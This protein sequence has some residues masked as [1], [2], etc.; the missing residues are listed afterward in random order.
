MPNPDHPLSRSCVS[1]LH[2]FPVNMHSAFIR[3]HGVKA[4][5]AGCSVIEN[6]TVLQRIYRRIDRIP[7]LMAQGRTQI[8]H[9][10]GIACFHI[11]TSASAFRYSQFYFAHDILHPVIFLFDPAKSEHSA[12]SP[13]GSGAVLARALRLFSSARSG[14][15][16]DAGEFKG[17]DVHQRS[18][19]GVDAIFEG[20]AGVRLGNRHAADGN[21][22]GIRIQMDSTDLPAFD[23]GVEITR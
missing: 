16:A 5:G 18:L 11:S 20:A 1:L 23:R 8:I 14:R 13:E 17:A 6:S 2:R 9:D 4:P 10:K 15:S 12:G 22:I 7:Q 21:G 3:T 19:L